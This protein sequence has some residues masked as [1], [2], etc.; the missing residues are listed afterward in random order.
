MVDKEQ[1]RERDDTPIGMVDGALVEASDNYDD[2]IADDEED[3]SP[4]A[5]KT[6]DRA[7]RRR[8]IIFHGV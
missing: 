2:E 5:K 1:E 7:P 8:R 6:N 4:P 3:T